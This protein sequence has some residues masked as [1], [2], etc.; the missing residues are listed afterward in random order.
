[1]ASVELEETPSETVRK[2]EVSG[3]GGSKTSE[4]SKKK[5]KT[6]TKTKKEKKDKN[7][8]YRYYMSK[9]G[10]GCV[11]LRTEY[12]KEGN[13]D[14][15]VVDE[16]GQRRNP[17]HLVI[18]VNGLIGNAENWR[19]A[20]KQFLKKYPEDVIAHCS[21]CNPSKLTFDGV[22]NMGDR[23]AEEVISVIKRHPGVQK[24]SFV[25]H[26]L[27]GLVTR[28]VIAKLYGRDVRREFAQENGECRS[29]G[30][31][32]PCPE[33][34]FKG[35][36]AGLE[37]MNFITFATPHLGSRGHKQVPV[38]CGFYTMEK[39][40]SR[41][42]WLLGRTG[43]HLFLTDKD[44]GK[45][46]LLLQMANDCE[47]LKFISALQSFKRRVTYA[48]VRYDHLVGWST[49]SLRR[50]DE[51]PKHRHLSKNDKYRHIVNV[52]TAETSSRQQEVLLE[53]KV[54]G[55]KNID[56]EEEML[57]GLTKVTWERID[58]N[59]SG[60]KQRYLAH[61]TIQVKNYC[62]NFAG[63]DVVYHMIDNFLL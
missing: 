37:P 46:P 15:E 16:D 17:T 30:S 55:F 6:K 14:M 47:D 36:I 29:D 28:Y 32:D 54:N 50:R 40:A 43:K 44:N 35:K 12:D 11:R 48:N 7:G 42:S 57:R 39:V 1:M 38:F 63:A 2:V 4:K 22:D 13:F 59:F 26:S 56:L 10:F 49:S 9:L 62:I 52:E 61:S 34:K 25:G 3:G 45:P 58:V 27:G 24:I 33:E 53:A 5:K 19:Y 41:A 60:T 8:A 18:M 20:A 23:L 31:G 21:E 51:L